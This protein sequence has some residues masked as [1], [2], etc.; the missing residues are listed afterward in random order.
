MREEPRDYVLSLF[1]LFVLQSNMLDSIR[2]TTCCVIQLFTSLLFGI[3][4]SHKIFPYNSI[5]FGLEN[6][7]KN[8]VLTDNQLKR[9][10]EISSINYYLER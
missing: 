10:Y 1:C 6:T 3:F 9:S 2:Q 5:R 8:Q 4:R 7:L